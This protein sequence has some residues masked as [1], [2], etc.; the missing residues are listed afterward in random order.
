MSKEVILAIPD[1]MYR[2]FE[3]RAAATGQDVAGVLIEVINRNETVDEGE[4]T[5]EPDEAVERERAAYLSLH[6]MLWQKYPGEYV[7][8]YGGKL[9]DHDPDGVALSQRVRRRFPNQF[10]LRRRVEAEPDRILQ[11]RSPRFTQDD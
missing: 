6:P 11:M 2:R 1:E 5:Y 3:R 9:V 10:V 4:L 7:A 8:I